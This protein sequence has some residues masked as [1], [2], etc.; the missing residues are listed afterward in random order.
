MCSFPIAN[1][2]DDLVDAIVYA[3]SDLA[4]MGSVNIRFL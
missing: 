3:L 1:E 2:H 4:R